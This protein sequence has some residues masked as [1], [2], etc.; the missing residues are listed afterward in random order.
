MDN[1]SIYRVT[2]CFKLSFCFI[3]ISICITAIVILI[4]RCTTSN[5]FAHFSH[6]TLGTLVDKRFLSHVISLISSW[7]S[8]GLWLCYYNG[9]QTFYTVARSH[10]LGKYTIWNMQRCGNLA[11]KV[12]LFLKLMIFERNDIKLSCWC[13]QFF[14]INKR[15]RQDEW[16]IKNI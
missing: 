7:K 11:R 12:W 16:S 1:L 3:R 5:A 14:T 4:T 8:F 6:A 13:F 9:E 15:Q 10:K 2:S